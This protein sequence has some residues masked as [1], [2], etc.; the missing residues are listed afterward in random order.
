MTE[1]AGEY[2]ACFKFTVLLL[3]GGAKKIS[4]ATF[5]QDSLLQSSHPVPEEIQILLTKS[6]APRKKRNKKTKAEGAEEESK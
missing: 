3:S 5:A 6:T 1:R 4:G 2:V